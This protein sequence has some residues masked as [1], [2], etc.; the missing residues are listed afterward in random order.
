MENARA[1]LRE[2]G[3]SDKNVSQAIAY[4]KTIEVQRVFNE[5]KKDLHW[6]VISVVCDICRPEL[7]FEIEAAA[8]IKDSK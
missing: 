7:L 8:L 3:C 6:P 4:C 1:V 2:T 5:F